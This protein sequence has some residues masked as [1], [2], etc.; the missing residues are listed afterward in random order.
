MSVSFTDKKKF[1]ITNH[2]Y[3]IEV[4]IIIEQF[5]INENKVNASSL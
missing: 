3:L 2:Q 1:N 4:H 5:E